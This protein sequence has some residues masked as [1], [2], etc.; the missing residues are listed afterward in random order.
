MEIVCR[1]T[2]TVS[3]QNHGTCHDVGKDDISVG[4]VR[5]LKKSQG[6]AVC[7]PTNTRR[8]KSQSCQINHFALEATA[9]TELAKEEVLHPS[10][11]GA[12][13]AD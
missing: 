7:L 13:E 1:L 4:K 12:R 8:T 11:H 2:N 9:T 6:G 3:S 10:F 5:K